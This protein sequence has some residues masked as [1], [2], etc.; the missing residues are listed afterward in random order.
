ML[1]KKRFDEKL[2]AFGEDYLLN[3]TTPYKGFFQ[4]LDSGRMSIYLD[5]T[6][7]AML[8]RPA[9]FLATSADAVIAQGNTIARDGRTYSVL[10]MS[11]QRVAGA[12]VAK[13]VILA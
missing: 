6:E 4:Q 9:L 7:R 12:A 8:T 13:I 3:G 10:K 2:A 1:L 5:D 11:I